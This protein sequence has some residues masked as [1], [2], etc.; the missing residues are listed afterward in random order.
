MEPEFGRR[1]WLQGMGGGLGMLGLATLLNPRLLATETRS[2]SSSRGRPPRAKRV[3]FLHQSGAPSQLDLFDYKPRLNDL[4]GEELPES[5][6]QGQRLTSMT[7]EQP[8]KRLTASLFSFD[9]HG[10]CGAYVSELLPFTAR[11]ADELCFVR[12]MHT[13]AINHDPAITLVQTGSQQPGRPSMGA[14]ISYG[15]GTESQEL[16]AFVVF[17]S[18]GQPGDQPLFARLWS[19]GFLP[20]QHQGVKFRGQ[21][22][23]VLYLSNPPGIR[24]DMRRQA[25]DTLAQLNRLQFQSVRD[26]EIETRIAQ[27]ELAYRMQNSVPEVANLADEPEATFALYG[28]D[29]RHSGTYAWNC[30]M[31]RR[32][33]ERGVRFVQLYHRDWDHHTNL[34]SRIRIKCHETDQASA[35]LVIDL[36]QRG[37]L[38]DTLVVWGGEFG[39]TAFCQGEL[40]T[41]N[42]GRDHHPRCFTIWLA[43][44]GVR[45]GF[46]YGTTD[47]FSYNVAEH[48]V[49][50]HDLQATLLACLG[51]DHTQLTYRSQGRDFRLTDI[52]GQVVYDVLR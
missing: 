40:G 25:L 8:H 13:E 43:G 24:P 42:Y 5:V 37:L 18:G 2:E 44:G 12:T 15:L 7:A 4:Q 17:L 38:D 19:S 14:W 16:P 29:S 51:I 34:P 48:P 49:H 35:A 11:I 32:L 28:E 3:I 39:R 23:P 27:F 41:A 22:D 52:A 36:K 1:K 26:P 33:I 45:P 10:E 9:R 50:V 46:T 6:R 31:A 20:T 47:D 30:L 21:G